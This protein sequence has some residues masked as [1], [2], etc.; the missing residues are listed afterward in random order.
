MDA[1]IGQFETYLRLG[2]FAGAFLLFSLLEALFPRRGRALGRWQRWGTNLGMLAIGTLLVRGLIFAAPLLATAAAAGFAM[3]AG[4][5]LLNQTGWPYWLDLLIALAALDL[6]IWFQ[7]VVTHRVPWL[8]RLHRIHHGD[9]DFDASTALRF[10]PVEIALS[11]GWKLLV[12]LALGP[13]IAAVILFEIL[14]NACAIFNH[15]NLALPGWLDRALRLV[16][17]TPDMH[18]VHHSHA[19]RE[20]HRNFGFCLSVWDRLFGTYRAQPEL[21]HEAMRIGLEQV[22]PKRASRLTDSLAGP[23]TWR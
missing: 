14:L 4:W 6:A 15:S 20:H 7:H 18:R 17:V 2:G 1:W 21:G 11:A 9:G 5:G 13:S 3:V 22:D 10:H 19:P 23:V 12:I 16:L 8:W